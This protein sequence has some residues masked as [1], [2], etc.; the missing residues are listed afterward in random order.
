MLKSAWLNILDEFREVNLVEV[1][2]FLRRL[3]WNGRSGL[4][5]VG[6]IAIILV[7]YGCDQFNGGQGGLHVL[8]RG[9]IGEP[10][11]LRPHYFR[12]NQSA[13]VLRDIGEGLVRYD[14]SGKIVGG[15]AEHWNI[16]G[17]GLSYNFKLRDDARWS[18]GDP[19]LAQE[20]VSALRDLVSPE[21]ASSNANNA[22]RILNA[23]AILRGKISP[24]DLGV[25]VD[26]SRR[27]RIRLHT[28]TPY[29]IQLLAH[30]SMYPRH[31]P[32]DLTELDGI[33]RSLDITNGAYQLSEWVVGAQIVLERNS[34]YWGDKETFFDQVNYHIVEESSELTRFRAGELDITENVP[35]TSFAMVREKYL[36]ELRVAPYLG[37][38]YYG[39][40]LSS[41][42]F[43]DMQPLRRA[44]SLAIDRELLVE[45]ITGRGEQKAYGWVPPGFTDYSSQS[46]SA[47]RMTKLEREALAVQL[48]EESGFG[49]ERPLRFEL[50]YNTS[51]VQKRI[52]VAIQS[53]WLDV[54]GA[55]AKLVN[56][57]FKVLISNIQA[58]EVTQ[59]FRL[60]WTGDYNDPQTFL[61]IFESNNSSNLTGYSN[62]FY[63]DLLKLA[64]KEVNEI[65][66]RGL[67]EEAES[68]MLEDHPVIPLY[69]YVSKHLISQRIVGW[70]DNI[71]D[72][73]A[74]Q[75]LRIEGGATSR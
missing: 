5:L 24:R 3:V 19:V 58:H 34:K 54:L 12:S 41:S 1:K 18:N 45:K 49:P 64:R 44:L 42:I 25:Y 35:S 65:E 47:S 27:L 8:N 66:R 37:I 16:S 55:E 53:M 70:E 48:Y 38:Y 68:V 46:I 40:N 7:S 13:S 26:G 52:A 61:E 69:F 60:S 72:I 67:L 20:F 36:A 63:D 57:E 10:E 43:T 17:D 15:V 32:K 75:Y 9:L 23:P 28:P 22:E 30:P 6:G 74:S 14:A 29:F 62:P 59:V 2:V 21:V 73:H 71:L 51:D 4:H 33:T 31:A 11:S 56:E 39:F 50:R